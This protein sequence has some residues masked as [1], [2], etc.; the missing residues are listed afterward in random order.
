MSDFRF[1]VI[2]IVRCKLLIKSYLAQ[3]FTAEACVA[4]WIRSCH[5]KHRLGTRG[6]EFGTTTGRFRPTFCECTDI[7][8]GNYF[9]KK[10]I[11]GPHI[12]QE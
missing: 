3:F 9:Q 11:L 6:R 1:P 7:E 5:H 4:K 2:P 10:L 12:L 8:N